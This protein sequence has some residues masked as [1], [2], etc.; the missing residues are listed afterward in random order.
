MKEP[1]NAKL[2]L[3]TVLSLAVLLSACGKDDNKAGAPAEPAPSL[4]TSLPQQ[5]APEPGTEQ[6]SRT[7]PAIVP[8]DINSIP[9]TDK[10]IGEFPFFAPPN[11]YKY[12]TDTMNTLDE[13][14]SLRESFLHHYPIGS[15]RLYTVQGKVLKTWL[16]NEKLKST[17][18]SDFSSIHNHYEKTIS[19][20]GGVKV[21]DGEV[22]PGETYGVLTPENLSS[23][24]VSTSTMRRVYAIRTKDTEA[25]FEIDCS[26]SGCAFIVTQREKR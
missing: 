9:V 24:S 13:S 2:R 10:D 17:S 20:A 3:L 5:V 15:D 11:G 6:G 14:I 1:M 7:V 21:Y 4:E 16:Y 22:K 26:V 12:V 18:G 8:F 19:A 25:W 23:K